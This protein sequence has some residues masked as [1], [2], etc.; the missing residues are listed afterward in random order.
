MEEN[1]QPMPADSCASTSSLEA[2]LERSQQQQQHNPMATLFGKMM[3]LQD[4]LSSDGSDDGRSEPKTTTTR[5]DGIS[6]AER[7]EGN[8]DDTTDEQQRK[9]KD[10]HNSIHNLP[11]ALN[12]FLSSMQK[13][14]HTYKLNQQ[15]QDAD[16]D[17]TTE[18]HTKQPI[19]EE[20][21]S[22]TTTTTTHNPLLTI[23]RKINSTTKSSTSS[24]AAQPPPGGGSSSSHHHQRKHSDRDFGKSTTEIIDKILKSNLRLLAIA[25][26]LLAVTYLLHSAVV[27]LFLNESMS[28]GDETTGTTNNNNNNN[29]NTTRTNNRGGGIMGMEGGVGVSASNRISRSGRERLGG[30]LF[31]KLLLVSAVVGPDTLDLLILLSWYTLLSFLKSLSYLAGVTTAHASAAGQAPQRGVLKLLLVVLS[32]DVSAAIVCAGL[33]H[34]AGWSMVV[35]LTCDCV[36][37]GVDV[38]TH[39]TRF[40]Q[41]A[42]ECLHQRRLV[43][44]EA[45]Q[46]RLHVEM[47]QNN[48]RNRGGGDGMEDVEEE[49]SNE[50][51]L[52]DE[53]MDDLNYDGETINNDDSIEASIRYDEQMEVLEATHLRHLGI[54]DYTAFVLGL[55]ASFLNI[56]HFLHIWSLHGIAFNLVDGVLALHLH[57]A[58]SA[59]GKKIAERRNHNRIARDLDTFF[60]DASEL[61]MRK[62]SAVGDVCCICLGTMSMGNVKKIGCGHLYHTNCLRE[63]VERARSIEAARCPLCRASVVNGMQFP[64]N[65]ST[66]NGGIPGMPPGVFIFGFGN[67]G[68]PAMGR[69]NLQ[70]NVEGTLQNRQHQEDNNH[71]TTNNGGAG[72]IGQDIEPLAAAEIM[73]P[74]ER[75]LFRFSTEGFLPSWLPI[76]AFSFEVVRRPH[77]GIDTGGENNTA[78]AQQQQEIDNIHA[79]QSQQIQRP[80]QQIPAMQQ[81]VEQLQ[82]NEEQPQLPPQQPQPELSFFR[83]LLAFAG[84]AP[85]S[86]EEEILA[87]LQLVDM[88]P[89]YDRADLLRELRDRGSTTRVVEAVLSGSFSGIARPGAM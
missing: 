32:C 12:R 9:K 60:E 68:P 6:T 53:A 19:Q 75:P 69:G 27:D 8:D 50:E 10:D 48:G 31:F 33:F 77:A 43:E 7:N 71:N 35:L 66:Q 82:E 88:F 58:I 74:N 67:N 80:Q 23:L 42:M 89:Q 79:N 64:T 13:H 59:A 83:R 86:P 21:R 52:Y 20:S 70:E 76:P 28:P 39:L 1:E 5:Q 40:A 55:L 24:N 63:I 49:D 25:N 4:G 37:L 36:L 26:L 61:E 73:N 44:I 15:Q 22:H 47:R 14:M 2:P 11:K 30:Y 3:S 45:R 62:A 51:V 16:T 41:Q 87:I 81:N 78:R 18:E 85:M 56:A 34:G 17:G 84:A 65:D 72:G 38:L 46:I 57:T 54:L 29:N